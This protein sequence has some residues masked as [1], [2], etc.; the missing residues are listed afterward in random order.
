[1]ILSLSCLVTLV[2]LKCGKR[3][4]GEGRRSWTSP[5]GG[6]G[7][8]RNRCREAINLD[9]FSF[10]KRYEVPQCKREETCPPQPWVVQNPNVEHEKTQSVGRI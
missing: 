7:G 9:S 6:T 1:M 5:Q 10:N 3:G 8:R 4:K 2:A